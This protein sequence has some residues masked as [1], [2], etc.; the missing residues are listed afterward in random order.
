VEDIEAGAFRASGTDV[1]TKLLVLQ[2]PRAV[3]AVQTEEST[4]ALDAA[5]VLEVDTPRITG[6][7]APDTVMEELANAFF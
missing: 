3:A 1:A 5:K 2:A 7:P 6:K 4:E